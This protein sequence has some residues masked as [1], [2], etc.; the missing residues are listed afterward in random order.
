MNVT[1]R[2]SVVFYCYH[3]I[4][5]NSNLMNPDQTKSETQQQ[6]KVTL[7]YLCGGGWLATGKSKRK[8]FNKLSCRV[9]VCGFSAVAGLGLGS[10]RLTR[11]KFN[12][13]FCFQLPSRFVE[14]FRT[15]QKRKFKKEYLVYSYLLK[16]LIFSLIDFLVY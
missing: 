11:E 9:V 6:G 16:L 5:I 13:G 14:V 12:E 2:D 15:S 8:K 10:T 4:Y 1:N 7:N 3:F